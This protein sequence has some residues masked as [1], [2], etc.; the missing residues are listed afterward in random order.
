MSVN[1]KG[2]TASD[3]AYVRYMQAKLQGDML[4]AAQPIIDQALKDYEKVIRDKLAQFVLAQVQHSFSAQRL[5][6]ELVIRVDFNPKK[7]NR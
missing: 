7:A 6:H 2:L 5:G 1:M 3:Q 4:E